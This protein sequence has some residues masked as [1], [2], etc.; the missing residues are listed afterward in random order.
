MKL[1][2]LVFVCLQTL[3]L[4]QIDFKQGIDTYYKSLG[5]SDD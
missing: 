5:Y 4:S 2:I 3:S 1:K